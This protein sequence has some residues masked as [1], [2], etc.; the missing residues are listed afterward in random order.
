M[1]KFPRLT[2]HLDRNRWSSVK[3]GLTSVT[4]IA[5]VVAATATLTKIATLAM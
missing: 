5:L 3:I 1:K 2:R 4:L